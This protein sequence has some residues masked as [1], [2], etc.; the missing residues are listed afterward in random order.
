M[1]KSHFTEEKKETNEINNYKQVKISSS[2][3]N[4]EVGKVPKKWILFIFIFLFLIIIVFVIVFKL[5]KN[6]F[7][8]ENEKLILH[9]L[10][11][12]N[13]CQYTNSIEALKYWYHEKKCI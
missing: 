7:K 8:R 13:N 10:G 12:M 1:Q 3:N 11:E 6:S 2:N 4:K 5:K 9:A